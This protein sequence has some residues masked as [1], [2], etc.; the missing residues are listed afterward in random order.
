MSRDLTRKISGLLELYNP[1]FAPSAMSS[2][3]LGA[4]IAYY[5]T[6]SVDWF[7]LALALCAIA[8]IWY[9]SFGMNE[10]GGFVIG[11][12]EFS[13]RLALARSSETGYSASGNVLVR[14]VLT[15]R[16]VLVASVTSY[17]LGIALGLYLVFSRGLWWLLPLGSFGIL[18]GLFYEAPP[19]KLSYRI[20]GAY[21]ILL[22][23]NVHVL[24]TL[25][26]FYVMTNAIALE[27]VL[28]SLPAF[29][30]SHSLRVAAAIP[31]YEA[32]KAYGRLTLVTYLGCRRS[33]WVAFAENVASCL[34]LLVEVFIGVAPPLALAALMFAPLALFNSFAVV[35]RFEF[36]SVL[37]SMKATNL[38]LLGHKLLLAL[39]YVVT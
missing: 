27:P 3:I 7:S 31:D 39:I 4:S 13:R 34:I 30:A 12:D 15:A 36:R 6:K 22:P 9:G 11:I 5:V 33:L 14:G 20:P 29:A 1:R 18:C 8:L 23:L 32:D 10:Y 16:Q 21:D 19:L 37:S 2:V 24:T 17:I 35:R 26:A 28:L 25:G 38:H